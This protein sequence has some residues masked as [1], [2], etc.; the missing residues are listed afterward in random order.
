[1]KSQAM[2][3]RVRPHTYATMQENLQAKF[4]AKFINQHQRLK[5]AVHLCQ[6]KAYDTR[7]GILDDL[8]LS[9][10]D[11]SNQE[12][13]DWLPDSYKKAEE[14]AKE[15]FLPLLMVRRHASV[16]LSNS[17]TSLNKCL[18]GC[19]EPVNLVN[20]SIESI[21][22]K[23]LECVVNYRK[24]LSELI[25]KVATIYDGYLQNFGSDGSLR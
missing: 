23:K 18:D 3:N 25:P 9:D 10:K 13:A 20:P 15:C 8:D 19:E 1:M 12:K 11:V 5:A 6:H 21:E 22:K 2:K 4:R 24:D 16:L 7:D 14:Q 17:D